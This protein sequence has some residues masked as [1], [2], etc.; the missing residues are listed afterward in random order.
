MRTA[1]QLERTT[2]DG[3][4]DAV[5]SF[6]AEPCTTVKN[7]RLSVTDKNSGFKFLVDSGANVSVIPRN[8]K[9]SKDSLHPIKNCKLY[10]ANSTE[11][12]TYGYVNLTLNLNL[13]RLFKWTFIVCDVKQPIIGADFLRNFRLLVDLHGKKLIDELTSVNVI[14]TIINQTDSSI[15]SLSTDCKAFNLLNKY[16]D[17][18][19]PLSFIEEPKHST[20]HYIETTGPPIHQ[21]TRPLPPDRYEK[22][23]KEFQTMLEM[24]ICRPSKSP[25]SSPLHIVPKKDGE[26]RPCGDYRALNAVTKPDRYPIARVHDFT[27][28]LAGKSIFS[29]VDIRRAYHNIMVHPD[30]VEKTAITTPF[31]LYEFPRM[32]FG[33]RNACQ[34]FQ[35]FMNN[36]VLRDFDFVYCYLDDI[37][38]ASL[39]EEEHDGHLDQ[40]FKRLSEFGITINL[41][42]CTFKEKKLEFLGYEVSTEGFK[43]LES[44]VQAIKDYPK[45]QNVSQLR[46]FLGMINFYRPHMPHAVQFQE[47]L[48]RYIHKSKRNDKTPI[49]WSQEADEAFQQCKLSLQNAVM[50]AYPL[51][52]VP[53]SLYADASNTC[54]GAVLQ[55]FAEGNWKPLAYFSK[56]LT[57]AQMKYSTYDK[58]LLAVYLS[59]QHF[60]YLH[61]GRELIV[62]TDHKPL[63]YAFSK[64]NSDN[65]KEI[66]RRT[67]Q[68]LFISEFTTDIRHVQGK[69]NVV[70]DA[71][72]RIETVDCQN[73]A[74]DYT[75]IS[76]A[77]END[78]EL[79]TLLQNSHDKM[80]FKRI[81]MPNCDYNIYCEI[82][83]GNA[84]P[85][86]P[87]KFR[88]N[89]FNHIHTLSHPG[90]RTSRKMVS[91]RFFWT[92]MNKDVGLWAK[93]CVQCQK[94][95][96]ARHTKT[97]PGKFPEVD[98]FEHIHTDLVGALPTSPEGYRYC[99]TIIDR[100]TGWPEAF[101]LQDISAETVAQTIYDGWIVRFGCPVTLTS[102]QGRQFESNLFRQLMKYTGTEKLRTTPYHP[103]ANSVIERWHKSLKAALKARINNTS[104]V[105]ELSTVLLG[106][107]TVPR[108]D[109]GVSAAQLVYGCSIRLPAE[110]Y[111][112]VD[113]KAT[114]PHAMLDKIKDTIRNLKPRPYHH[115]S[116]DNRFFV[117]PDLKTC[118][119]V[120]VRRIVK[121]SL[122]TPYEGPYKVIK[123]NDKVFRIQ[124][125]D[126]EVNMTIDRL[127]PA[128]LLKE[129]VSSPQNT[130]LASTTQADSGI[131][132]PVPSVAPYITRSGR[133]V[134]KSV[135][136]CD[137]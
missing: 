86:I 62:F 47:I 134:K 78:S 135:R 27:Y 3:K 7:Y 81:M 12:K 20:C 101:P 10:A 103:E 82:S 54:I 99:L 113:K 112:N 6:S 18:L 97:I 130:T 42:K 30:D 38:V 80:Q 120:F 52:T 104:W 1:V 100:A 49:E 111:C 8:F 119:N 61:E 19:K 102:D 125:E 39:S 136:F 107:R 41:E 24:G 127:K 122:Q 33:L 89:V 15:T 75:L 91:D 58:E 123:R 32:S 96:V 23:K 11:I 83:T 37:L 98:R 88:R 21:R 106:L 137:E 121:S 77:Q 46:T 71:L 60:R 17:L 48:Q 74:I 43:P 118:D 93:T 50:L 16:P 129:E 45:P 67:R 79:K 72:S 4:L 55:Q 109:T 116:N 9:Y 68:L 110:F 76:K 124:L 2:A 114:E 132:P 14:G 28:L 56:K 117:S 84:R 40:L 13:R 29:C 35:R 92:D 94:A 36:T 66:P 51:P 22:A 26:I 63:T 31:G 131:A 126:R 108:T 25:W 95:K 73:I 90:V 115:H 53:I 133:I 59:V 34:T 64:I 70:A 5:Q 65:N 105:T 57:G 44:K 128:Y 87:E 69:D 85:F